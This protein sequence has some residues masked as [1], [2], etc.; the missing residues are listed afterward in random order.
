[1]ASG[2]APL[3]KK[4]KGSLVAG[5]GPAPSAPASASTSAARQPRFFPESVASGA[6]SRPFVS[7]SVG[8]AGG[9]SH[10]CK[11]SVGGY[12]RKLPACMYAKMST[13]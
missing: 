13:S 4:V 12:P 7:A 3:V 8:A 11:V 6:A 1:M 10:N 5:L 9:R 2:A